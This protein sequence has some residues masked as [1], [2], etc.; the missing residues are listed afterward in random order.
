MGSPCEIQ[1]FAPRR[2]QAQRAADLAIADVN[3]LDARYSNYR[4]DSFLSEINRVA[5]TG[6]SIAVDPETAVLFDY[7]AACHAQSDGLFDITCGALRRVWQF[8][9]KQIP[10]QRDIDAALER[11]GWDKLRWRSPVM[12]FPVAGLEI[13]FGG[14]VK[15]YAADRAAALCREQG[16]EHGVVN[17]GGDIKAI[18]PRADGSPWR[19]GIR[20]PRRTDSTLGSLLL[21][22]G[23]LATSGDYERCIEVDG[24]RYGHIFNPKTGWPV[25]H[26]ASVSVMGPLCTVAGSASTIGMLREEMGP[27]WLAELGLAHLWVDTRGEMGGTMRLA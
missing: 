7:A 23:A 24:V 22:E 18:G 6:G 13:D 4:A 15:E 26:M 8:D 27:K 1:L 17:L 14:V 25:R 16:L 10:A 3:R 20:H 5:A 19:V 11:I 21:R 12:D 2:A 9:Q